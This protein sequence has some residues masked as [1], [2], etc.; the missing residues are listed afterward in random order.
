MIRR[1]PVCIASLLVLGLALAAPLRLEAVQDNIVDQ[2]GPYTGAVSDGLSGAT[3]GIGHV[4]T[5]TLQ[6]FLNPENTQA[7]KDQLRQR[8]NNLGEVGGKLEWA[9]KILGQALD[10]INIGNI[11]LKVYETYGEKGFEEAFNKAVRE[12][13]IFAAGKLGAWGGA[14]LGAMGGTAVTP[15]VGTVVGGIGGAIAGGYLAGK[16]TE[17]LYDAYLADHVRALGGTIKQTIT[18]QP[19]TGPPGGGGPVTTGP[20]PDITSV[21]P[22]GPGGGSGTGSGTDWQWPEP[23]TRDQIQDVRRQGRK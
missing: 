18:G 8:I 21:P 17:K 2:T 4:Q 1:R 23:K 5:Q 10:V 6:Q 11:A 9:G 3:T 13:L 22:L 7:I 20:P 19:P 16:L 15:G 14:E 12:A